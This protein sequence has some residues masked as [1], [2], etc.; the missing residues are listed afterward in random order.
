MD[1]GTLRGALQAIYT[2]RFAELDDSQGVLHYLL[3]QDNMSG[4]VTGVVFNLQCLKT[5]YII[6]N[7]E[8]LINYLLLSSSK[9]E[10]LIWNHATLTEDISELRRNFNLILGA[11]NIYVTRSVEWRYFY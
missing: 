10:M 1:S 6:P 7:H 4:G 3:V 9:K 5:K 2:S 8:F 11:N